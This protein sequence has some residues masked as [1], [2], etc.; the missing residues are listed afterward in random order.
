MLSVSGKKPFKN[1]CNCVDVK[2][3]VRTELNLNAGEFEGYSVGTPT[4]VT[5]CLKELRAVLL[6]AEPIRMP[7]NIYFDTAG[8]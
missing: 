6:F 4:A 7:V 1:I 2:N 3:S 5:F 8:K